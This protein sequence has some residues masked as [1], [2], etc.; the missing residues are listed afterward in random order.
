MQN[1][2]IKKIND[3]ELLLKIKF[4]AKEEKRLTQEVLDHLAEV[5]TRRL[6]AS[7]G[8]PSLFEFCVREL[9]YSESSAH[10][11]ISAMRVMKAIPEAKEKFEAGLVNL[12]TLTQLKG[13]VTY[14]A[15]VRKRLRHSNRSR[16]AV[17]I[18]WSYSATQ[19]ASA[20]SNSQSSRGHQNFGHKENG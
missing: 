18:R 11:R 14:A 12:S 3:H 20:F 19:F 15:K 5:E 17:G 2:T 7:R 8:Y 16:R 10:R 9:G 6:F 4:L 13:E 1:L